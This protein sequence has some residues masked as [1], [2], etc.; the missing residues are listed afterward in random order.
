MALT[1]D[2]VSWVAHLSRIEIDGPMCEKMADQL[3][4]ILD[5][6][7][8]LNQLDTADIEP[9]SHPGAVA[10]VFRDDTPT[11]S[12]ANADALKNAPDQAAGCFRVPRVIE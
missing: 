4:G 7:E 11:G 3:S 10:N 1:K 9:L 5:Y 12:L 6:I 2:E 8:K